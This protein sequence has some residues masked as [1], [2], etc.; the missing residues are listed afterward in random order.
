MAKLPFILKILFTP[1]A[2][3]KIDTSVKL[4]ISTQRWAMI[5][6]TLCAANISASSHPSSHRTI[7]IRA[8]TSAEDQVQ[9]RGATDAIL[10]RLRL[11]VSREKIHWWFE[12]MPKSQGETLSLITILL[13]ELLIRTEVRNISFIIMPV[14][15]RRHNSANTWRKHFTIASYGKHFPK[16]NITAKATHLVLHDLMNVL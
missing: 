8:P 15:I 16:R 13:V 9:I 4:S 11:L 10:R 6:T 5:N 2:P 3:L 1:R 7:F 12:V 14:R